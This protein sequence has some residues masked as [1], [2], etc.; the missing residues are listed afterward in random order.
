MLGNLSGFGFRA[1]D[2]TDRLPGF[3]AIPFGSRQSPRD[4]DGKGGS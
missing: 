1:L 3:P 2:S 4:E